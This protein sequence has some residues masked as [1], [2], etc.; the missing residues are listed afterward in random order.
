MMSSLGTQYELMEGKMDGQT[1]GHWYY[2]LI[3]QICCEGMKIRKDK[4][5]K[6]VVDWIFFIFTDKIK[7]VIYL[8]MKNKK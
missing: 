6:I 2:S 1:V 4:E 8:L 5:I 7:L 3:F